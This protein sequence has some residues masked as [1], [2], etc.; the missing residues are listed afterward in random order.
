MPSITPS[1]DV[2]VG[3]RNFI[4]GTLYSVDDETV[5]QIQAAES[6]EEAAVEAVESEEVEESTEPEAEPD[7]GDA[8]EEATRPPHSALKAEWVDWAVSQGRDR[9]EAEAMTKGA[10][11]EEFGT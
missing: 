3:G 11:I 2:Q 8:E 5:A 6:E 7:E 10:L 1:R 4:G 9:S